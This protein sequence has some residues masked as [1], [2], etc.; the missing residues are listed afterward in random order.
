MLKKQRGGINNLIKWVY[1][2]PF[3]NYIL[4][5]LLKVKII[6]IF[7][8]HLKQ[9]YLKNKIF[10]IQGHKMLMNNLELSINENYDVTETEI[11]KR[12]IKRGDV[13][14]DIGAN[15]GF[16]TLIFARLVGPKGKV[17]AFEPDPESFY[18]LKKNV[19]INGYTNVILIQKAVSNSN[20]KLRLYLSELNKGDHRIWDSWEKRN[21]IEI[22]S[23]RLD[24]YFK[25][26]SEKISFIKIDTQGAEGLVFQGMSDLL[27]QSNN[28]IIIL[29]FWPA[30]L[31]R[32][33]MDP[34]DF[35]KLISEHGFKLYQMKEKKNSLEI[36]NIDELLKI[37]SI[38]NWCNLFLVKEK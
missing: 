32:T 31:K 22:E 24:D 10:M 4:L 11:V 20:G 35:L 17:F 2:N 15:V 9:Q 29:E 37:V 27:K 23:I 34:A 13:V 6:K 30:G 25:N 28:V 7:F 33:G 18:L 19:E 3:I 5:I 14:L 26:Y 36:A 12:E 38:N 1:K 21:S 8:S 16:Y